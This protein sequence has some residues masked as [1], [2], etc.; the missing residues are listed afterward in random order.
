M[1][2]NGE[3][4]GMEDPFEVVKKELQRIKGSISEIKGML[5]VDEDGM[6][7]VSVMNKEEHEEV[8]ATAAAQMI[9]I[10]DGLVNDLKWEEDLRP[11]ILEEAVQHLDDLILRR[12]T[13]WDDPDGALEIAQRI[14]G[15]FDWSDARRI[16]ELARLR[17]S[18]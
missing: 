3:N 7:V 6:S 15:L 5:L 18:L 9:E 1:I 4:G 13:L 12:T 11:F 10:G 8:W 16:E 17:K 14:S 2:A